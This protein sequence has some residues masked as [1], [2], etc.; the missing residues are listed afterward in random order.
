MTSSMPASRGVYSSLAWA[1]SW[2]PEPPFAIAGL[3]L[4][5]IDGPFL[6]KE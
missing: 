4:V 2:L 1:L 3:F 5:I 6:A